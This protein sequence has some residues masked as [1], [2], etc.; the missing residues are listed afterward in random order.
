MIFR[1]QPCWAFSS[2]LTH[3]FYKDPKSN[4]TSLKDVV[5]DKGYEYV[6]KKICEDTLSFDVLCEEFDRFLEDGTSAFFT[7]AVQLNENYAISITSNI[8]LYRF[9][10]S[11]ILEQQSAFKWLYAPV[12]KYVGD[13]WWYDDREIITDIQQLSFVEFMEKYKG[14]VG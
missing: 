12:R 6:I 9:S 3:E 1:T 8:Y 5:D 2:N 11:D 4:Y 14:Y 7:Y 13:T 10:P